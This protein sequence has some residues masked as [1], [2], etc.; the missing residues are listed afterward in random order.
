MTPRER[1]NAAVRRQKVDRV[2]WE[3]GFTPSVARMAQLKL[4]QNVDVAE[5][6]GWETRGVGFRGPRDP[7][8]FS[9]YYHGVPGVQWDHDWGTGEV[10]G[11]FHH[12]ARKVFPLRDVRS[13]EG[14]SEY[15][16]PDFTPP[17]RHAHLEEEIAYWHGRGFHVSGWVGH[18]WETAWQILGFER[19]FSDLLLQPEIPVFVLDKITQCNAFKARRYAEAGVD[20]LRVGD[21]VGMQDRLMMQPDLW[22]FPSG[23]TATATSRPSSRTSSKSA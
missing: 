3:M 16:W 5:Y 9:A 15:P 4:G 12:F 7:Q 21:D 8:D 11:D 6:F 13:V 17:E 18:I 23:I 1:V 2:P 22:S 14:L 19:T 10:A 20:M